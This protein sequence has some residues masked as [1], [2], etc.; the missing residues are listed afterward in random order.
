VKEK[1]LASSREFSPPLSIA[2]GV[3]RFLENKIIQNELKPGTRLIERNLSESL[4]V[5]R[6]SIRE[7]FRIL[8]L[9]GLVKIIPRKGAQ[10]TSITKQE[11]EEIYTLRAYLVGL[12][13]KLAARNISREDLEDLEEIAALMAEK[14]QRNDLKSYFSLNLKFH[15]LLS[16]VGGNQRLHQVLENFG[17]QT[18]RFRYAS[19]SLP[20]RMRKSSSYH[21]RLVEAIR[22]RDEERA[23]KIA[24]TI[25][26]EAGRALIEHPFDDSS[27]FP[28]LFK[29]ALPGKT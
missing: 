5:S 7:A 1:P 12:G 16:Q 11:V 4:G 14:S 13:A 21:Q 6:I 19:M 23:E 20:G 27:D 3:A 17:K 8:A 29:K 22:K 25:I 2:E 10:V 15:R 28:E 24:R 18:H 9:S 26:E